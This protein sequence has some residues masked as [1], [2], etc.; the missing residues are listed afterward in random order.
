VASMSKC[1]WIINWWIINSMNSMLATAM[2]T[3][4]PPNKEA[5]AVHRTVTKHDGHLRAEPQAS[6]F[7]IF[8][9]FSNARSVLSQ[10]NTR[11]R[12]PHLLSHLHAWMVCRRKRIHAMKHTLSAQNIVCYCLLG[13][14]V[15]F[16]IYK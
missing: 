7:F 10:C 8:R 12:P 3:N 15:C 9:V 14:F 5:Q 13:V 6:V 2:H 4:D 16:M 1:W 11:P